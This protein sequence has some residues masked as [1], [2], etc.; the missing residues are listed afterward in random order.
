MNRS[1]FWVIKYMNG[2]DFS[3]ARCMNGVAFE[4]LVTVRMY[5][6]HHDISCA[7]QLLWHTVIIFADI[8]DSDRSARRRI[9][10]R[11]VTVRMYVCHHDIYCA[12]QLLWHRVIIFADI[13]DS[14]RSARRRILVR[15]VTVRMYV[16]HHDIYCDIQLLYLRTLGTLIE[17]RECAYWSESSLSVCMYVIMIYI[18]TY[19]YYDIQLLYLRTWRLWSKCAEAHTAQNRHCPYVCMY[20]CMSSWYILWHTVIIF[21][22]IGDSDRSARRRILVRIVTVRMYVCMSSWYI[23]CRTVI[24]TYSYYICGHWRLW[25]KCAE[26]HTGQNRHCPYVCMSSWYILWHTVIIFTDIG[27]SERSARMRILVSIV[28]VR[29]YVRYHDKYCHIYNVLL[30]LLYVTDC[31]KLRHRQFYNHWWLYTSSRRGHL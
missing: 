16:C 28:T 6:C 20:V 24:M 22:D 10:V 7:V 4:I 25:S 11:I 26:A 5:V 1:T 12:V 31:R 27:D 30:L 9:L 19:R 13:G 21:A 23:L 29:M 15:I 2:S 14:D 17:V 18:V 3:K 8:G